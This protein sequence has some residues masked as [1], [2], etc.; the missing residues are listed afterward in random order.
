MNNV[1]ALIENYFVNFVN[2]ALM[3]TKNRVNF[4]CPKDRIS[5]LS[6]Y[7]DY[8]VVCF[9]RVK[10]IWFSQRE[11]LKRFLIFSTRAIIGMIHTDPQFSFVPLFSFTGED[12]RNSKPNEQ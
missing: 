3:S 4:V 5:C 6:F 11:L 7:F 12:Q 1:S 8:D 10:R 2:G 9:W